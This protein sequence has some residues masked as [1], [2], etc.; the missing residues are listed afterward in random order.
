M[1]KMMLRQKEG[2]FLRPLAVHEKST[3]DSVSMKILFIDDKA[4]LP[5]IYL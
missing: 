3:D 4:L 2:W 1:T 5:R